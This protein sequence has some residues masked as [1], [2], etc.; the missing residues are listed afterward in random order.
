MK[1]DRL[2]LWIL[3]ADLLW[4]SLALFGADLLRYGVHWVFPVRNLLPLIFATCLLWA[5]LSSWVHLDGFRGGWRFAAVVSHLFLAVTFLLAALLAV[6][7]L[8]RHYVS[9]LAVFYFGVL[10]IAGFI[11]IRYVARLILLSRHR[12]GHVSRLIIVGSGQVARELATKIER[13]PE[14]LCQVVGF[15]CPQET[16]VDLGEFG[17]TAARFSTVATLGVLDLLHANQADE[18][19][20]A[21]PKPDLPEILNLA[22][23]CREEGISVSLVPQPYE[24][25]LSKPNLLDLDGLPLLRVQEASASSLF[26]Y[27]KRIGDLLIGSLLLILTIPILLPTAAILRWSKGRAFRWEK[28]CG[29]KGSRFLMLRLNV[30]RDAQD[31]SRFEQFL[32]QLSITELPQLFNVLRGNMSLVG[33]RPES[34]D[35]VRRY[36]EWQQQRLAVKPGMTGLAQVHGLRDQHSSEE[37]TRFDLQYLLNPSPLTDLSLLLQTFWTLAVRLFRYPNVAAMMAHSPEHREVSDF[38]FTPVEEVLHRAHRP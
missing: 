28:R 35:R 36:S 11:I 3:V 9:R 37:K 15:L 1:T 4:V 8:A 29:Q 12:S 2:V 10:L 18:L 14:M 25:Y 38:S 27:W 22:A 7:Y 6:G 24:L 21:L 31:L 17:A 30:D 33:P 5:L 23:R 34:R 20:L 26:F 13:H 19:I 32:Q 16:S